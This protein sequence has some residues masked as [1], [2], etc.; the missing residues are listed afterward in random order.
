[1]NY[2]C[3]NVCIGIPIWRWTVTVQNRR[4][5]GLHAD[6]KHSIRCRCLF[7]IFSVFSTTGDAAEHYILPLQI[8]LLYTHSHEQGRIR[9]HTLELPLMQFT[10]VISGR[11]K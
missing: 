3:S 5:H 11:K 7:L 2:I 1:M 10:Q 4:R 9:V 8:A 6:G